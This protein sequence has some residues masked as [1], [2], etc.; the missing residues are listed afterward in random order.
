MYQT[1]SKTYDNFDLRDIFQD[2]LK[3]S[4]VE[5]RSIL[6][7]ITSQAYFQ[8]LE[9]EWHSLLTL[10]LPYFLLSRATKHLR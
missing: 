5:V 3:F 9:N 7:C 4:F 2:L 1:S 6:I 10:F 8:H